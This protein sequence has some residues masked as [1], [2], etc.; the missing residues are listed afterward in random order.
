MELKKMVM[1]VAEVVYFDNADIIRTS[2]EHKCGGDE[3]ETDL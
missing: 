3:G 1:P 2:G